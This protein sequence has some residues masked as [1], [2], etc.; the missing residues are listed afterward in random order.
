LYYPAIRVPQT[1]WFTRVVLYWD[2]VGSIVPFQLVDQPDFL[3]PY[4]ASLIDAELLDPVRPDI[5]GSGADNYQSAFLDLVDADPRINTGANLGDRPQ[6]VVHIDKMS[7]TLATALELRDL[8]VR[9]GGD[10]WE[11]EER[12]A[13][14]LMAYLAAILGGH[15]DRRMTPITDSPGCLDVFAEAPSALARSQLRTEI[16][17]DIL[18][19]PSEVPADAAAAAR[20]AG[21]LAT[22]KEQRRDLLV[23]FRNEVERSVIAAAAID[24]AEL[25]AEHARRSK[26]TFADQIEEISRRMTEQRWRKIS[27]GTFA[28]VLGG[29]VALVDAVTTGGALTVSGASLGLASAVYS[30]FEGKRSAQELLGQPMAYA[31]L[32]RR[33]LA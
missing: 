25:R 16:L 1:D 29:G 3:R 31:A 17:D 22:F 15:P 28:G 6:A 33:D 10:W 12:T 27:L 23:N 24:D 7:E 19:A 26:V 2:K 18:P 30:A 32:A 21:E 13:N 4:T 11:V 8:A 9:V 5:Y 20:W 14:L